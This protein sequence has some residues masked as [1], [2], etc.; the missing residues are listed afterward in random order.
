MNIPEHAD[1]LMWAI[2]LE[3]ER[4]K[5]SAKFTNQSFEIH[6]NVPP[7]LADDLRRSGPGLNGPAPRAKRQQQNTRELDYQPSVCSLSLSVT[8]NQSLE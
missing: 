7:W 8:V 2:K 6:H 3:H 4:R 1:P 5:C